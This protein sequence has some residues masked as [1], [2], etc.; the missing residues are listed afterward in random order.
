MTVITSSIYN[1]SS[2]GFLELVVVH[3]IAHQWFY[4]LVGNDNQDQPWLDEALAEFL[5]W[6]YYRIYQGSE[7]AG[8]FEAEQR[9]WWQS[10]E[11]PNQGIGLPV[12]AYSSSAYGAIVYGKGP[13]FF[14]ALRDRIGQE[15]FESLMRAY[16]VRYSWD[17]ATADGFRALAEE[18]CGCSL[19]DLFTTWITP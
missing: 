16:V 12:D 7:A 18:S 10:A 1:S 5:S 8:A 15:L 9:G 14:D 13:F 4:N 2:S 6:E 3:E 11:D 17:I 19:A